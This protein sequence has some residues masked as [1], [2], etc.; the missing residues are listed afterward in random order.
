MPESI[1]SITRQDEGAEPTGKASLREAIIRQE[2]RQG[3]NN[4]A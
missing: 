4:W 2:H 3:V 1:V